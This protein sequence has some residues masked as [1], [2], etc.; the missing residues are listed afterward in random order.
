MKSFIIL[1]TLIFFLLPSLK[2]YRESFTN[3]NQ[4]VLPVVLQKSSLITDG[5]GNYTYSLCG[6][7]S[8]WRKKGET[9]IDCSHYLENN[10]CNDIGEDGRK[11]QDAC[12]ISCGMCPNKINIEKIQK[13]DSSRYRDPVY[14]LQEEAAKGA[15]GGVSEH[16]ALIEQREKGLQLEN[17]LE[18]DDLTNR[19]TT[20]LTNIDAYNKDF[21]NTQKEQPHKLCNNYNIT[22]GC[23]SGKKR[24]ECEGDICETCPSKDKVTELYESDNKPK[25]DLTYFFD[26][27]FK[28]RTI[29]IETLLKDKTND[30]KCVLNKDDEKKNT[31]EKV[32]RNAGFFLNKDKTPLCK[33]IVRIDSSGK[34]RSLAEDCP[35]GCGICS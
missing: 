33:K 34:T 24:I 28:R 29:P 30:A 26:H 1:F 7:D 27:D 15:R 13:F 23:D 10:S 11:A 16:K 9:D 19:L 14:V 8:K 20:L 22:T 35:Y 17:Y 32:I 6:D 21:E 25:S 4:V 12:P 18:T 2:Y 3:I 31:N 5:R